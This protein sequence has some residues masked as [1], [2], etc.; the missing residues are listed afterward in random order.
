MN[1]IIHAAILITIW[2]GVLFLTMYFFMKRLNRF[3]DDKDVSA[4]D[5]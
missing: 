5:K 4:S 2:N 1:N 3:F